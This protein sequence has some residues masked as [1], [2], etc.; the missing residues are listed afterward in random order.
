MEP[1]AS[2]APSQF[3][4]PEK[5]KSSKKVFLFLKIGLFE[6]VFFVIVLGLIL[7]I[8]NYLNILPLFSHVPPLANI[9]QKVALTP[10][11]TPSPS[12]QTDAIKQNSLNNVENV[13]LSSL[14]STIYNQ[15][16]PPYLGVQVL[17]LVPSQDAFTVEWQQDTLRFNAQVNYHQ[18]GNQF[19]TD[20]I[21]IF[22]SSPGE[23]ASASS[24]IAKKLTERYFN[25]S[26]FSVNNFFCQK[27]NNTFLCQNFISQAQAKKGAGIAMF[28]PLEKFIFYC[29]IFSSYKSFSS[30]NSCTSQ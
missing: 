19:V 21:D 27:N 20:R 25:D 22:I 13:F 8:L 5:R 11:E 30:I 1:S 15:Y 9:S 26:S 29:K 14:R 28:N 18:E 6:I 24:N 2:V 23:V 4:L 10:I 3:E 17:K 7:A 16:L 12:N